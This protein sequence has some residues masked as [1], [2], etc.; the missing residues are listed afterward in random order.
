MGCH[1]SQFK[2][3][4]KNGP[5]SHLRGGVPPPPGGVP[6]EFLVPIARAARGGSPGG[7]PQGAEYG[8]KGPKNGH[9]F[10]I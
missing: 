9:F 10:G 5:V 3:P 1:F 4:I 8:K 6:G 7:A 2:I